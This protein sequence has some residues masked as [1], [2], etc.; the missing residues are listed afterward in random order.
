MKSFRLCCVCNGDVQSLDFLVEVRAIDSC[1][2]LL[3]VLTATGIC[4][5]DGRTKNSAIVRDKYVI[6]NTMGQN[7]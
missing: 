2:H 6:L 3:I 7:I 5:V 4:F 1:G